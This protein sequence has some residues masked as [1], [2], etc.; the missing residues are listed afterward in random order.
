[1]WKTR[2]VTR[3]GQVQGWAIP[4]WV[5]APSPCQS[6]GQYR[7]IAGLQQLC[8][9]AWVEETSRDTAGP[10]FL[11]WKQNWESL[12]RVWL[13]ATHGLYSPWN[14]QGQNTGEGSLSLLQGSFLT[15]GSNPDLPYVRQILYQLSYQESPLS[16]RAQHFI[17]TNFHFHF[18]SRVVIKAWILERELKSCGLFPF[19]IALGTS[20]WSLG[21]KS[22][23]DS[24]DCCKD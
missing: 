21:D 13:F 17:H 3:L 16:I 14:S 12:S 10:F 18:P 20:L 19:F 2:Q 23:I 22:G 4:W 15:Q 1:M 6:P 7:S 24:W 11:H 5:I 9:G 8:W